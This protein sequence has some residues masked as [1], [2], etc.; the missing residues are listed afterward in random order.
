[1]ANPKTK[2]ETTAKKIDKKTSAINEIH[3]I[4]DE[5]VDLIKKAKTKYAKTDPKTKKAVI[6]GIAGAAALIAGAI[7]YK[8]MKKKK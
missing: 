2:K 1:M 6:A 5:V 4:G 7:G 3:K 8:A